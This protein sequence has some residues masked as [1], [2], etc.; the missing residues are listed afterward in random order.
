MPP[1]PAPPPRR[2]TGRRRNEATR[3]AI[4]DAAIALWRDP[5]EGGITV[6][7]LAA[8]S[9]AGRQTIYRWWRSKGAV[10]AEALAQ[11]ARAV[12]PVP[13]TGSLAGDLHRFLADTA[14]AMAGRPTRQMLHH[15]MAS[16]PHDPHVAEAVADFTAQRRAELRDLLERSRTRGEI[17]GGTDLDTLVDLAYGFLW[18]RLLVGHAPLD[19]QAATDLTTAL[20]AIA[21]T[22]R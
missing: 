15:L 7:A 11:R 1:G 19:R 8:A 18:Y 22:P 3:Q 12:A 21:T 2:H 16:A 13:D 14:L 6:D 10:L 17:D 5:P 20:L 4:L 9:G